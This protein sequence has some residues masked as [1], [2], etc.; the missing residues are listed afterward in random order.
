MSG[1][2]AKHARRLAALRKGFLWG[3]LHPS[4]SCLHEPPCTPSRERCQPQPKQAIAHASTAEVLFYGGA[5]GGG[6][7]EFGLIEAITIC[8][9]HKNVKV[10]FFRRKLRELE[11]E[12]IGRFLLLVPDYIATYNASTHVA[13]FWQ[14]SE[15]WFCHCQHEKDVYTY[16]SAQWVALFIDES[17]HFTEFIVRYLITRVRSARIGMRKRIRLMS[18]PGGVGHGFHKRW[19]IRPVPDEL[20]TRPA[21]A[22]FAIWRPLPLPNDPTPPEH[23]PTRQFIP[24]WFHDNVALASAD[25]AYL[26]KVWALGGDKAKQLAEGDWDANDSMIVGSTWREKRLV[27]ASDHAL[28]ALGLKVGQIIPW[29]II[30]NP[31]WK[32]PKGATIWGSVDYGYG[33]PWAFHLH[34]GLPGGHIRTFFEFYM[35]KKRDV[36]QARMIAKVLRE[37]HWQPE[38]IVMDPS[39]WN[40]RAEQGLAKSIAEVY[41]DEIQSIC[42]LRKGAAGRSARVSRPQ[43]WLAALQPAADGLPNWTVTTACP[44]LIR[45]VPDVPWDPEDPEVEDD[46]SENHCIAAGTLIDT[47]EG[48]KPIEQIIAGDL[49]LTRKGYRPVLRA[50]LTNPDAEVLEVTCSDGRALRATANHR[51]FEKNQGFIEFGELAEGFILH[52]HSEISR[53]LKVRSLFQTPRRNGVKWSITSAVATLRAAATVGCTGASGAMSTGASPTAVT[54]TTRTTTRRTTIRRISNSSIASSICRCTAAIRRSGSAPRAAKT[55]DTPRRSAWQDR[56][57]SWRA[58]IAASLQQWLKGNYAF[59]TTA[60]GSAGGTP[61]INANA[62]RSPRVRSSAPAVGKLSRP[63]GAANASA[64]TSR[65]ITVRPSG[66]TAVYDLTVADAHEF[67]ANGILVHNCYEG[68]GRFF[69]ARPFVPAPAPFDPYEGLDP[70]SR[71]HHE[72][73]EKKHRSRVGGAMGIGNL[74][75]QG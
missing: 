14:G 62:M 13:K 68:V 41:A 20:G 52:N 23:V 43:R 15:L 32:P 17:T 63:N 29:H 75:N 9:E 55:C 46:S 34:A 2:R 25:P 58:R 49:V 11:Q 30:P 22:P 24:A 59:A 38:W 71:A 48:P 7:S 57:S 26:A 56:A 27:Q 1:K 33:A 19:F 66:R 16:Q 60:H 12:I 44:D 8:L 69:E 42:Q 28:L 51:V 72:A 6:K 74:A 3:Y 73:L 10:A 47:S 45:T 39:M 37:N 61:S 50:W 65:V 67:F 36:E 53:W 21:P 31:Q 40:S 35:P 5:V 4:G 18:N 70:I 54:S 64:G